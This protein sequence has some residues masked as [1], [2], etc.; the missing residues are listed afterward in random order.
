MVRPAGVTRQFPTTPSD[1]ISGEYP[2]PPLTRYNTM[3]RSAERGAA[4]PLDAGLPTGFNQHAPRVRN[5]GS[6]IGLIGLDHHW[7]PASVRGRLSF[8]GDRLDGAL[9]ALAAAP[10]ITEAVILSTCNR[11]EVYLAAPDWS[12]ASATVERFLAEVHD[13]GPEA[14]VP[15]LA[16]L[17]T[18][19]ARAAPRADADPAALVPPVTLPALAPGHDKSAAALDSYLYRE[20]GPDAA[21]HLLRV[22]AGL[23]SM[24]VGESQILG[25]VKEALAAAEQ[26][27]S[28]GDEL[29]ALFTQAIKVG[30]RARTDTRLGQVDRSLAAAGIQVAA[31]ALGGLA[32]R[33]A[34][35]IGA[36]RTSQLCARQLRAAGVGRLVLANRTTQA[37]SD[38]AAE[39]AAETVSL[40]DVCEAI[41]SVDLIVSATAAPHTVL[42]AANVACGL[43]GRRTP[44]VIVDL[45]V[46]ADVD[47]AA[48]LLPQVSLHTL[49]Q[50]RATATTDTAQEEDLAQ[51]EAVVTGGVRAWAR[52]RQVRLAVPGIAALRRHVD[53]SQE[54]ELA[55]ALDDLAHLSAADLH[56]IERFGQRL[57]DKMFHHLVA[58]IR[59]LAEYDEVPPEVTMRV[60]AQLFAGPD[61]PTETH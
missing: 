50:L 43:Q 34:L 59:S 10:T 52:E 55:R 39:V 21:R 35:V 7:A 2:M 13:A 22:A 36:G 27:G 42:S 14:P 54:D 44:L 18:I 38:L 32:G 24:L 60:L 25:Q 17:S 51:V 33:A 31:E 58:R 30:K 6:M 8:S 57:V 9:R 11:T 15:A 16:T 37:A 53:R 45:A 47:A 61:I 20:D 26:A 12:A 1:E 3:Q 28:V 4:F 19:P 48:G 29:R 23:R 49:D 40:D 5:T 41:G 46:P 56:I